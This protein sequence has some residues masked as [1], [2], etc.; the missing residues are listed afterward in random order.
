MN[1][2]VGVVVAVALI[3]TGVEAEARARIRL[4]ST[5]VRAPV[6]KP[7]LPAN[8]RPVDRGPVQ[9]GLVVA[10]IVRPHSASRD[11]PT[12]S[13]GL[14]P[15]AVGVAAGAAAAGAAATGATAR[16]PTPPRAL[17]GNGTLVG[18]GAG[19]CAVN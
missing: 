5:P 9:P 1:W 11:I 2:R 4:F 15:A 3:T 14:V 16:P 12:G 6:A 19:F 17:C 7:A 8:A 18:Q 10:P 13:V